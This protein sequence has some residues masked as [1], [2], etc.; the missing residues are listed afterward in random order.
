MSF[1]N[2]GWIAAS[3]RAVPIGGPQAWFY[4]TEWGEIRKKPVDRIENRFAVYDTFLKVAAPKPGEKRSDIVANF[5]SNDIQGIGTDIAQLSSKDLEA[6][7]PPAAPGVP[8]HTEAFPLLPTPQL[9]LLPK[10]LR[11]GILQAS[12]CPVDTS[13]VLTC[14]WAPHYFNVSRNALNS[15]PSRASKNNYGPL[16]G[17]VFDPTNFSSTLATNGSRETP[18]GF[19]TPHGSPRGTRGLLNLP[20]GPGWGPHA[21][22]PRSSA[23]NAPAFGIYRRLRELCEDIVKHIHYAS[24]QKY[25]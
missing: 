20:C 17:D 22:P 5:I 8:S 1:A 3:R 24:P 2:L 21:S 15:R 14:D 10:S 4:T 11:N 16:K 18:I 13:M 23:G 25:W 6:R 12:V 19:A 7:D 9:F